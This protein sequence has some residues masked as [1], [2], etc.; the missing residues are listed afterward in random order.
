M[1]VGHVNGGQEHW[2]HK[3]ALQAVCPLERALTMASRKAPMRCSAQGI[4]ASRFAPRLARLWS[5]WSASA[6]AI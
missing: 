2:Q 4:A 1:H 5:V 6:C 3:N